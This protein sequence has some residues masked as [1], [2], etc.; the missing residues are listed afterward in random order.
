[1]DNSPNLAQTVDNWC[2]GIHTPTGRN[3][4]HRPGGSASFEL[5]AKQ[6]TTKPVTT[7]ATTT[8]DP[9]LIIVRKDDGR[10]PERIT[11]AKL[12]A[13]EAVLSKA[14]VDRTDIVEFVLSGGFHALP[15]IP[16]AVIDNPERRERDYPDAGARITDACLGRAPKNGDRNWPSTAESVRLWC[17]AAFVD[18]G[19]LR[20]SELSILGVNLPK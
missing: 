15:A 12:E 7:P 17:K 10:K 14:R 19:I 1:M 3:W 20:L 16:Q 4:P 5:M 9:H 2:D 18:T 6:P 8:P 11:K 13:L